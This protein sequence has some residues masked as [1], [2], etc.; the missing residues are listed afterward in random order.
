MQQ[1]NAAHGTYSEAAA[2]K[3]PCSRSHRPPRAR[4]R[5]G[6]NRC[7][8][9]G[10]PGGGGGWRRSGGSANAGAT[11][12]AGRRTGAGSVRKGC[13]FGSSGGGGGQGHAL[14]GAW[15]LGMKE[16]W[17]RGRRRRRRSGGASYTDVAIWEGDLRV[18]TD[19]VKWKVNGE[20]ETARSK[21][22]FPFSF[23]FR[24][25]TLSFLCSLAVI[26]YQLLLHG[27][28]SL[29]V[30]KNTSTTKINISLIIYTY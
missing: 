25:K 9:P 28:W 29:T 5:R 26:D 13:R 17:S 11:A 1:E 19:A 27:R 12:A 14:V 7:A 8:L 23:R 6:A 22:R 10:L 18:N 24:V 16:G 15:S 21:S 3:L 20:G 30:I 4:A 2:R